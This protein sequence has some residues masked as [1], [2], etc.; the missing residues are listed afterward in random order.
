LAF[1]S[2]TSFGATCSAET[3]EGTWKR[4][5][6]P[7]YLPHPTHPITPDASP[8]DACAAGKLMAVDFEHDFERNLQVIFRK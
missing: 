2:P 5:I 6:D 4:T 8:R 3:A 7:V 1:Q